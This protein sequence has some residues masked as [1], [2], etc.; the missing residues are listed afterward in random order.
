MA[1]MIIEK[2]NYALSIKEISKCNEVE[3]EYKKI[4]KGGNNYK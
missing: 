2:L 3:C 1:S 4:I